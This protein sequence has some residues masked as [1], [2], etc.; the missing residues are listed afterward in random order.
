[1]STFASA[2]KKVLCCILLLLLLACSCSRQ[3]RIERALSAAEEVVERRADS[4][5]LHLEGI[6]DIVERGDDASR[7]LYGLLL[8]EAKYRQDED[9]PDSLLPVIRSSEELFGGAGDRLHQERSMYYHAMM[10][11]KL[12]ELDASVLKLKEGELL[13]DQLA[14]DVFLSKYY[15]SLVEL[16]YLSRSYTLMLLYAKK[17]LRHSVAHRRMDC[18]SRAFGEIAFSYS[19]LNE[20]DSSLFYLQHALPTLDSIAPIERAHILTNLGLELLEKKQ[21]E[22]ALLYFKKA[23]ALA[24]TTGA[25]TGLAKIN[26][27][28]GN[29][30]VADSL[31]AIALKSKEPYIRYGVYKSM[32]LNMIR[33]GESDRAEECLWKMVALDDSIR[34]SSDRN[35][36]AELQLKYDQQVVINRTTTIVNYIFI[37]VLL[38]ILIG[39]LFHRFVVHKYR[40]ELERNT[41][42]TEQY[43]Q[44]LETLSNEMEKKDEEYTKNERQILQYREQLTLLSAS[45]DVKEREEIQK[46]QRQISSLEQRNAELTRQKSQYEHES[47]K[48]LQR[49]QLLFEESL[50]RMGVG[51]RV[52]DFIKT[53]QKIPYD[54]KDC[55]QSL[56]AFYS[57]RRYDTYQGWM[58]HY[59]GL[60][61]RMLVY[62]ILQDMGY[63][64]TKI[65]SILSVTIDA[66]K[67]TKSRIR[68]HL[69]EK[70]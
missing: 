58:R 47:R 4:A 57:V 38:I 18:I 32:L 65:A 22:H 49:K 23:L 27:V 69:R 8:T 52:Y 53:E 63:D 62:L 28:K 3:A 36:I 54:M 51:S 24:P 11:K 67:K 20:P 30:V 56:I 43:E 70:A 46:K 6:A 21:Y 64:D 40:N 68:S 60:T 10:L 5:L 35:L 16:N 66:V 14:D 12:G 45:M 25:Y 13:A 26:Y 44:R 15:E 9:R 34:A 31:W 41:R 48:L 7:A 50:Y 17:F 33:G 42:K 55:E 61:S 2:M 37:V 1:M 39:W 29:K 59:D 19:L